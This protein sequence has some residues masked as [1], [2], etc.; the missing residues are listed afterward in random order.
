MVQ[1]FSCFLFLFI[2]Y[3]LTQ[4]IMDTKCSNIGHPRNLIQVKNRQFVVRK[5]KSAFILIHL[6]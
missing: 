2:Y 3:F 1:D 4:Y 5:S 6:R